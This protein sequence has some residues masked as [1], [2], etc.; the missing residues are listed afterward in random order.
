MHHGVVSNVG[1]GS[2]FRLRHTPYGGPHA[3]EQ[4]LM[5]QLRAHGQDPICFS[6]FADRHSAY[7]FM[8]GWSEY[9]TPNLK[10]GAETAVEVN[11]RVLPW[12]RQNAGRD[13]YLL[14]INYWDIH[15]TYRMD[16][17][18]ADR[19]TDHPVPLEWPDEE[20]IQRH[21]EITGPF[22]ATGQFRP[23]GT[24]PPLMPQAIRSRGDF[25]HM[26][27]GYDAAI[28]YTDHHLG[29]VLE[30]LDR[31]GVLEDA[32]IVIT[33]DHGDAFG[34]HGIY[35]DHVCADECIH[36][37]PLIVR[38]PGTTPA[39]C[40]SDALLYNV[41]WSATLCELLGAPV[42]AAWDGCSFREQ[43][44]GAEGG[45]RDCL[46]WNHGLYTVQRAVRTPQHLLVRTYDDHGYSFGP[47]ELYDM[48]DDPYQTRDLVDA[49]PEIAGN[50]LQHMQEWV[51]EQR[52]KVGW[53]S[54]PLLDI[55]T[56]RSQDTL[57]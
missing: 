39:G 33:G 50:L 40:E 35:S 57:P 44:E 51:E 9:H 16:A 22:T 27:T 29:L 47:V 42:P 55:L 56:E 41:D 54:D 46:V 43:V 37:I 31:Q 53:R 8:C 48:E 21:Q 3:D 14:H 15:R 18:W 32:A 25:E 17:S 7:W 36:R 24:P 20:T 12:L 6:N 2:A 34:E 38:W 52:A 26:V 4:L 30:E 45:G 28:A 13:D 5:R 11:D 23:G 1:V 49:E 19:F 10:G